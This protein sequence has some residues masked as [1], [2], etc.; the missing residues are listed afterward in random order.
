MLFH[1]RNIGILLTTA[2]R[3]CEL[4]SHLA[5]HQEMKPFVLFEQWISLYRG[6]VNERKQAERVNI[7]E[8]E[9]WMTWLC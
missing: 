5:F 9:R 2:T 6:E 7:C 4:P 3:P 1:R 8:R